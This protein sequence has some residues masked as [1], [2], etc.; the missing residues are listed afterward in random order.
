ME[1]EFYKDE[2]EQFLQQQA[3]NHRMFPTDGVWLGIY[4]KLHGEKRWPGL[5]IAAFIIL[6]AT[7]ATSIYFS[8]KPN[9]FALEQPLKTATKVYPPKNSNALLNLVS[10]TEKSTKGKSFVQQSNNPGNVGV[11]EKMVITNIGNTDLLVSTDD[12]EKAATNSIAF[13]IKKQATNIVSSLTDQAIEKAQ[14]KNFVNSV[15]DPEKRK[16]GEKPEAF[17]D[18]EINLS[19]NIDVSPAAN[20]SKPANTRKT[21]VDAND[22]NIADNFLKQ[23]LAD[24]SD[25]TTKRTNYQKNKFSYTVYIAPSISYRNLKED[26]YLNSKSYSLNGP[27][28]ANFVTDVNKLVRHK[29]GTGIEAGLA[30]TYH[31]SNTFGIT[32]G[33]QFNIRQYNIEAYK[34]STELTSI[35][36]RSNSG[37]DTINSYAIY[38]NNNGNFSTELVNRYYQ[39]SLP[40]GIAWQVLGNK[41]IQFNVAANIQPTYTFN[42][43]S[44]VLSTNFKNYTVNSAM[45]RNWTI[46]SNIETNI[47]VKVGEYKWQLGPQIRYQHLPTFITKYPIRENLVDYGF[48]IGVAKQIK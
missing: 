47:S 37:V 27:V 41:K 7:V 33:V 20:T 46:N 8:P 2:F 35:T 11:I 45:L 23:H 38:R 28:A 10:N 13:N 26:K 39:F 29:P 18:V 16:D 40:I 22:K 6:I 34:S 5:T 19:R 36:L 24:L 42:S 12:R 43:D 4:K 3:N 32:S 15:L 14:P 21:N 48:K 25:F 31:L 30:Y 17:D 1:E 9:I 44:Y